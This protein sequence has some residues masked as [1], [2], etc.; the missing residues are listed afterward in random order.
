MAVL[1]AR[2]LC[3]K[4]ARTLF[5]KRQKLSKIFAMAAS[6]P[7]ADDVAGT[8]PSADAYVQVAVGGCQPHRVAHLMWWE[9]QALCT[10]VPKLDTEAAEAD[11]AGWYTVARETTTRAHNPV[12]FPC[13]SQTGQDDHFHWEPY[14][15]S[16]FVQ[17][18]IAEEVA[19]Q[20][21]ARYVQRERRL[22]V[23]PDDAFDRLVNAE[24]VVAAIRLQ[25]QDDSWW[26]QGPGARPLVI[27][28]DDPDGVIINVAWTETQFSQAIQQYYTRWVDHHRRRYQVRVAAEVR[29]RLKELR[30]LLTAPLSALVNSHR[31]VV[32]LLYKLDEA[33]PPE[34]DD[35]TADASLAWPQEAFDAVVQAQVYAA[36]ATPNAAMDA[37]QFRVSRA[38]Q[39]LRSL[40][41]IHLTQ[42]GRED[43][44][45]Q[46]LNA[47]A[48]ASLRLFVSAASKL[49]A[50]VWEVLDGLVRT[51]P[52][53][54]S[55]WYQE[56]FA[57]RR[58]CLHMA[59]T[60]AQLLYWGQLGAM[61]P[62]FTPEIR[63]TYHSVLDFMDMAMACM[64]RR[65][66]PLM[67]QWR[68]DHATGG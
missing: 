26:T 18:F 36:Y 61:V 37:V 55:R 45:R 42:P 16:C 39:Q 49:E 41:L 1:A 50:E 23:I 46:R 65:L 27:T 22:P 56:L 32:H 62:G 35:N 58:V 64:K 34:S 30:H 53:V 13:I 33:F 17:S 52:S 59:P 9:W 43:A 14:A 54:R 6:P 25:P 44:D 48:L 40:T 63:P 57:S 21:H 67:T 10:R 8:G 20:T 7:P 24:D 29:E 11:G 66:F 68:Q 51:L 19:R 3:A 31:T 2:A 47:E 5:P 38:I 4:A 28:P 12:M 15:I 60:Q